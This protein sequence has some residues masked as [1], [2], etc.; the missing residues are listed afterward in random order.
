MYPGILTANGIVRLSE[1][2]ENCGGVLPSGSWTSIQVVDEDE[3]TTIV[4][5]SRFTANGDISSNPL[6]HRGERIF[7]PMALDFVEILGAVYLTG[8]QHISQT[9]TGSQGMVEYLPGETV[10]EMLGRTGGLTSLALRDQ[11]FIERRLDGGGTVRIEADLD[12]PDSDPLLR[13]GDRLIVPGAAPTVSVVG[14]VAMPGVFEYSAGNTAAYYISMAG[15]RV[16]EAK[17]EV[18]KLTLANGT[19]VSTDDTFI[20]ESGTVIEV[21]RQGIVW[22]EDYLL[23]ATGIAS[24]VIAYSSIFGN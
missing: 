20:V 23:I 1:I 7:V 12:D 9:G 16:H 8:N 2:L 10:S 18:V 4:D 22:W 15:G 11:C 21:P 5:L 3:D 13:P 14:S 17:K 24:V 6:I 19:R